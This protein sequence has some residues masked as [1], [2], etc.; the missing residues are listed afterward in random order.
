MWYTKDTVM[1]L[2]TYADADHTDYA[3]S[4]NKIPLYCD[5]HSAIALCCNNVQHSRSK[6][7]DI[8]YHFIRE[9][10]ENGV[11]ELY[12]VMADYQLANIYTKALPRE[13]FEFLL[14]RLDKMADENVPAKAPIRSDNQIL[15][16]SVWMPIGK[17]NF[18]LD[19]QK[20]QKNLIFQMSV[21]ILQNINFFRLDETRFTLDANIL[22]EAQE[23]TPIDQA[24]QFVSPSSSDAIMDFVNQLR[25]TEVIHFVLRM[26]M[27]W[28]I[29]TSTNVDYAEL[30]WEE[31]VQAIQTFLTDK[32]APYYNAYL[33]MVLKHDLK[34]SAEKK[35]NKKTVSAKQPK[36]MPAVE[37]ASKPEPASKSKA[38]KE[39]PSKPSAD[40]PPK[41][42]PA[43]E[44]S[45]MTTLP[46]PTHKGKGDEDDMELAIRMS[47]ET[48]QAQSQAHVGRVAIREPVTEATRPF[49]VVKGK[50]KAI[51][52]EEQAA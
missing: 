8:R 50:G 5:N 46:Q 43:K 1:A 45:T 19:L 7:I 10:V 26:T 18:V 41:L 25:Y 15:P 30:L 17:T 31:F 16:F 48:F 6:H 49:P 13:R 22:R 11:V 33:E 52:T 39:R 37:K 23:I 47:L 44:K 40:E 38:S 12:F 24:H 34:M 27:L 14:P 3:F 28:G 35:G 32:N 4:F 20:K 36:S 29:I 21:D 51:V 42:K 2:T 9:Q